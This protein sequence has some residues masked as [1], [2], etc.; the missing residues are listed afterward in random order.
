[1]HLVTTLYFEL[2]THQ[3]VYLYCAFLPTKHFIPP[4]QKEFLRTPNLYI[5]LSES[6]VRTF[7]SEC[8]NTGTYLS[9]VNFYTLSLG[10]SQYEYHQ[11]NM[12]NQ[13]YIIIEQLKCVRKVT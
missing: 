8:K 3:N 1:M 13:E 2:S 10:F 7:S 6:E 4:I 9:R 5:A 12:C 11:M